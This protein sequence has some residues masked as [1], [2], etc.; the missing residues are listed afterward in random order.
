MIQRRPFPSPSSL[1]FPGQDRRPR[2][3]VIRS[4]AQF[5]WYFLLGLTAVS[6]LIWFSLSL[7]A[8]TAVLE[9]RID[10]LQEQCRTQ[11]QRN[12]ELVRKIATETSIQQVESYAL[13]QGLTHRPRIVYVSLTEVSLIEEKPGAQ[14]LAAAS[15]SP[16]VDRE[17]GRERSLHHA[18][19]NAG[20]P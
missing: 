7:A 14:S 20:R 12:A 5:T 13:S 15:G 4:A 8:R 3:R 17:E 18:S 9:K 16:T 1:P 19:P 10:N 11:E 6:L 2:Q